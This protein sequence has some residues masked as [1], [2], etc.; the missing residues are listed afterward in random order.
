MAAIP[1]VRTALLSVQREALP[2]VPLV[3]EGR[4]AGTVVF[5][6]APIK[7][8]IEVPLEVRQSRRIAQ[9]RELTSADR[10]ALMIEIDQRDQRDLERSVAPTIA[11]PDAR[12][13]D[14]SG[15]SLTQALETMY[16][17]VLSKGIA[18]SIS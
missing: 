2:G 16:S 6:D 3:V 14:N 11:A 7:F 8:F 5:P 4:D 10:T 9:S 12:I 17:A 18:S 15:D 13:I 1:E